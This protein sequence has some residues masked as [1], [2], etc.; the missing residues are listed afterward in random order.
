M[1]YDK[2]II[3]IVMQKRGINWQ[4][5]L[6]SAQDEEGTNLEWRHKCPDHG[7]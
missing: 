6:G 4:M 2:I 3:R 7:L 1:V 5:H